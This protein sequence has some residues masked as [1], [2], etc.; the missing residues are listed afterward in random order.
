MTILETLLD[1]F[2]TGP[3]DFCGAD[4]DARPK[5]VYRDTETG[6]FYCLACLEMATDP[7]LALEDGPENP[8][9]VA[10]GRAAL[11]RYL[12]QAA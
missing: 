8:E 3:C 4:G 9:V 10:M 2:Q 5:R 7:A 6:C 11:D 1:A 12:P